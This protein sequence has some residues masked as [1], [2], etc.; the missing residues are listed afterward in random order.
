MSGGG[1]CRRWAW[2]CVSRL[3]R[4]GLLRRV[5]MKVVLCYLFVGGIC[6]CGWGGGVAMVGRRGCGGEMVVSIVYG[7]WRFR[8]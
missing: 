3:A 8:V 4:I 5:G 6:S 1:V 2:S 7:W